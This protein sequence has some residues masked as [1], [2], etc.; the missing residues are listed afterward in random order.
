M[1]FPGWPQT[2][3]YWVI[4]GVLG[5]ALFWRLYWVILGYALFTMKNNDKTWDIL[6][7]NVFAHFL[8]RMF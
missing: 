2:G 6:G 7:F 4:L 1:Q 3:I 5:F 8:L